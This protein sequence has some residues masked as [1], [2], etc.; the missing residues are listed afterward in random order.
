MTALAQGVAHNRA[1][2]GL[3]AIGVVLVIGYHVVEPVQTGGF[4]GVDLFFTLSGYLITMLMLSELD[5]SDTIG[6]TRFYL[7]R[8]VRLY[9]A[10]L[11]TLLLCLVPGLLLSS[12][13]AEYLLES[14]LAATYLTPFNVTFLPIGWPWAHTWSLG[15]EQL[16]YFVWPPVLRAILH[17]GV[18]RTRLALVLALLAAAMIVGQV[19]VLAMTGKLVVFLRASGVVAGCALALWMNV[20][21]SRGPVRIGARAAWAA[22]A[23]LALAATIGAQHRYEALAV[24]LTVPASA[25]LIAHTHTAHSSIV[26]ILE[27]GPT[28]YVGQISYEL[29]LWHYPL[30]TFGALAFQRDYLEVAWIVVPTFVLS[31]LTH[32]VLARPQNRWRSAVDRRSA[33]IARRIRGKMSP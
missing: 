29:Y 14:A 22:L 33:G 21:Q 9:P 10:L 30:I 19:L 25:V 18:R 23:V 31:A 26:R 15:I 16:F 27:T 24:A 1:L 13:A 28:V 5:R 17:R 20:R 12:N 7:R 3:R 11:L 2:D 4:V 6:L 32:A 8:F